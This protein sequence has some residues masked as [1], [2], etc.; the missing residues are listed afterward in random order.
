[1]I[2]QNLPT[3]IHDFLSFKQWETTESTHYVFH[4]T[5]GSEAQKDIAHIVKTQ[6]EAYTKITALLKTPT[7]TQK[8]TYYFYPD[9]ETK[10]TLM[11]DDWYALSILAEW[12]VHVLYTSEDKPI[13]P[14]EDTHLL[15]LHLGQATPFIAEGLADYMVEHAWDGTPHLE[16]AQKGKNIGLDMNPAHY[17]TPQDWF[18]TPDEHAIIFYSLAASWTAH[19]IKSYG[20]EKYLSFYS[21]IKRSMTKEEVAATYESVFGQSLEVLSEEY[22]RDIA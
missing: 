6:E 11:G 7:P 14:H 16:Y 1:M 13:G 8:I 3:Y 4:Y 20:L 22:M 19:L 5:P 18:D 2:E 17:L 21:T 12:R 9:T 15:S 10:K